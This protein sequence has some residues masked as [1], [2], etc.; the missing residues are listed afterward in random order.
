MA[1]PSPAFLLAGILAIVSWAG[2][3]SNYKAYAYEVPSACV[4]QEAIDYVDEWF[5]GSNKKYM[6]KFARLAFHDCIGGC[7]G[8]VDLTNKENNGLLAA[9]NELEDL[10]EYIQENI[11]NI[12]RA[13][14]WT[15]AEMRAIVLGMSRDDLEPDF[16]F[17]V[18]RSN[19]EAGSALDEYEGHFPNAA[20]NYTG[21]VEAMADFNLTD[22]ELTALMG[23]HSIGNCKVANSGYQGEWA[24]DAERLTNDYY[25][26]LLDMD[27]TT[28]ISVN[29][30]QVRIPNTGVYGKTG[31]LVGTKW[32]WNGTTYP[33]KLDGGP[34]PIMMLNV[35]MALVLDFEVKNITDE[36]SGE[37]PA[38]NFTTC[39]YN[40]KTIDY[41]NEY[42]RS[43]RTWATD[44]SKV[45]QK[46]LKHNVSDTLTTVQAE[47]GS[48]WSTWNE[49]DTKFWY[50]RSRKCVGDGGSSSAAC[51]ST[52][53]E[54]YQTVHGCCLHATH[55]Q[56]YTGISETKCYKQLKKG[57]YDCTDY[58]GGV[59][60]DD[61]EGGLT[62][63]SSSSDSTTSEE[64]TLLGDQSGALGG[65]AGTR[66]G[67]GAALAGAAALLAVF[68]F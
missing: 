47:W 46:M 63:S 61:A 55:G 49:T 39:S 37:V 60:D 24:T 52:S 14:V 64:S 57:N 26:L 54:T 42:A 29:W 19:C 9:V 12:S 50:A 17:E 44:F 65:P 67:A 31:E 62:C 1:F 68:G 2:N 58:Y 13:D 53:L 5:E 45:F 18:G 34:R 10:T 51:G 30:H 35:D 43:K 36:E 66:R 16:E 11:V 40:S 6:T 7:D 38:C 28:N 20:L 48:E 8:C 15:L 27:S 25:E 3:Q 23:I 4:L 21:M 33:D 56:A 22:Q 32:Q 59:Y 41:V